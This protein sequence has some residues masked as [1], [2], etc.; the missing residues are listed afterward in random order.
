VTP[1]V[2]QPPIAEGLWRTSTRSGEGGHCVQVAHV[3]DQHVVAVRDSKDP[4]GG[5]L[6][7]DPAV[8]AGFLDGVKAGEFDQP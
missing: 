6:C 4:A 8:F 7:F 2:G 5:V 3:A 1:S